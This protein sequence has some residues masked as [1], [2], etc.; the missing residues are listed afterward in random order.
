V[1]VA[2]LAG[3]PEAVLARA[4]AILNSLEGGAEAPLESKRRRRATPQLGLFDEGTLGP[5]SNKEQREVMDT[6]VALD[7]E[8]LTPIEA[9]NLLV[10]LKK[11]LSR[12]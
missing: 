2:K 11:R 6:L 7:P 3:L 1:A 8:R 12:R 4:Q 10:Q 5:Q 9:L